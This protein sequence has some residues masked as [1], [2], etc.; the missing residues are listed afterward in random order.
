MKG[1]VDLRGWLYQDGLPAHTRSSIQVL[2]GPD[3]RNSIGRD[4]RAIVSWSPYMYTE[5]RLL[6]SIPPLASQVVIKRQAAR[7][8]AIVAEPQIYVFSFL[9]IFCTA[10]TVI[11]QTRLFAA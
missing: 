11:A 6:I 2:T 8:C 3:V 4:Q 1:W 5:Q 9:C 7:V 10:T